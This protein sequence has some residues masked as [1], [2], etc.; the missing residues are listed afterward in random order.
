MVKYVEVRRDTSAFQLPLEAHQ[1]NV[2]CEA[3]FS[4]LPIYVQQF[5]T[6]KFNTSYRLDF[7]HRPSV[8]LRVA[9][10]TNALL[11]QHEIGLLKRE[12]SVQQRLNRLSE[13]FPVN[14]A[15]D[16]SR[17]LIDRDYVFQN[18]VPGELW[19]LMQH[20][21][22]GE[23]NEQLWWELASIVKRIHQLENDQFGF[24]QPRMQHQY[25][26]DAM[27]EW[28]AGMVKD[29]EKYRI[30]CEGAKELLEK[31]TIG[32]CYLDDVTT[33]TLVHGD[34]WPKN[35]LVQRSEGQVEIS[36]VLDAERAFWG[37][38]A[39]E[40]IFSFL[41]IPVSFW[42]RYGTLS[43]DTSAAFRTLVYEGRGAVQLC[44][45]AWRFGFDDAFARKLLM[46]TNAQLG[47]FLNA[48]SRHLHRDPL[49]SQK[50]KVIGERQSV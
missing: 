36:G 37:E 40:W 2:L 5:E 35:I 19:S 1:I 20:E 23:Q 42:H 50:A 13:K 21:L 41:D 33:P 3:H 44:L 29:L 43:E 10:P 11:F 28:I 6:G 9:P 49:A 4:S 15:A 47:H 32:R 27:I 16:F 14:L 46:R 31:V 25:W 18:V 39:A 8:I 38:P 48:K 26:G 24:P 22:T 45:E 7:D 30:N 12:H 17:K 34:L